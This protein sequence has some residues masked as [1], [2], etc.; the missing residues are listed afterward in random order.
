MVRSLQ[1]FLALAI[2]FLLSPV[3]A[4]QASGERTV[5][6]PD[7]SIGIE[8]LGLERLLPSAR[9]LLELGG[10]LADRH[11]AE[12]IHRL[13][14]W[15]DGLE[16]CAPADLNDPRVREIRRFLGT[17]PKDRDGA[18]V[19]RF[20]DETRIQV[21]LQRVS[22]LDPQD[23]DQRTYEAIVIPQTLDAP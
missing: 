7:E 16:G 5:Q 13:Q 4:G 18:V 14:C 3:A 20:P 2:S 6:I 11:R 9:E 22:D 10:G 15:I 19:I 8:D 12:L 23:W 21:R 17:G 1:T